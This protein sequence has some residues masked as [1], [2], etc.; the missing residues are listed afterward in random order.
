MR[1]I[2]AG[3]DL[4]AARPGDPLS[5]IFVTDN[6]ASG[7]NA[8]AELAAWRPA[9]ALRLGATLGLLRSRYIGYRVGARDLDG[10]DQAHAPRWQYSLSME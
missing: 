9:P 7:E 2:A 8:G 3:R 10:R 1:R 6:A 4:R 5:F